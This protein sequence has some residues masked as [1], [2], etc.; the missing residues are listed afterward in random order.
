M[1]CGQDLGSI[2]VVPAPA[3]ILVPLWMVA[4]KKVRVAARTPVHPGRVT[5]A[6]AARTSGVPFCG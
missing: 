6:D 5:C 2:G 1:P 3:L 4:C